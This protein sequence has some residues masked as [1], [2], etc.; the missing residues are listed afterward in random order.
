MQNYYVWVLNAEFC[1]LLFIVNTKIENDPS[2][3]IHIVK[4]IRK[5]PFLF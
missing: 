5:V 1:Q 3:G 2:L 4:V